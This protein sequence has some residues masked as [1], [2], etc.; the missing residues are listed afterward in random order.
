MT[1]NN[2]IIVIDTREQRPY[3]FPGVETVRQG[4]P[5]G[6]YSILGC[7]RKVAVERKTKEDAYG[8]I[9]K[10]RKRF[11]KELERLQGYEYRAIVIEC[12]MRGF[13]APPE[14][15]ELHPRAAIGSILAWGVKYK[16]PVF[17]ADN[18]KFGAATTLK[19][20]QKFWEY[21]KDDRIYL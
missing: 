5:A 17:F 21:R 10:G 3:K 15:S 16:I 8:T 14:R 13:M 18:R 11:V 20:L 12:T 9:G 6:D 7:E 19:L 2:F 4:L 1:K